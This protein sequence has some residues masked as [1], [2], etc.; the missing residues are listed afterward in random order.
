MITGAGAP[1]GP[2]RA[3]KGVTPGTA[4]KTGGP[5]TAGKGVTPGRGLWR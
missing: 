3:G 5:G 4:G 2:G 1:G